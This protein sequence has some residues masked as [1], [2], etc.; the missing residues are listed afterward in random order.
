MKLPLLQRI[1]LYGLLTLAVLVFLSPLVFIAATSLK[2]DKEIYQTEGFHFF[3]T[4][5]T[6]ENYRGV[7][8]EM[9]NFPVYMLNTAK[10]T[11]ITV[12]IVVTICS[13]CGYALAKLTF[14]GGKLIMTFLLLIMALPGMVLLIPIYRLEV[15]FGLLN[16]LPGLIL[17]YTTM[18]LPIGILIMR[19]AFLA[20][21]SD[22]REA[23]LVD[24]ASE[25]LTFRVIM[26]PIVRPSMIV[27]AL[28]T[29]LSCWKEYTYA[30]TL[31]TLPAS[32]TIAV[33]IT[34]LKNEAQSWPY[35]TLSAVIILAALPLLVVFLFFQRHLIGGLGE[36]ALKG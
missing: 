3:P 11:I 16:T 4:E 9:K 20:I 28:M 10:V 35:D 8:A 26:L 1:V 25:L 30:V 24:G 22:L 23:A 34:H 5:P 15:Y 2:T 33:G 7:L 18:F 14:A 36:G 12:L 17:P 13:L 32:T 31:N 27:V 19:A 21:P 6:L 29:F